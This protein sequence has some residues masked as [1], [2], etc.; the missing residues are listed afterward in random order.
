MSAVWM[1]LQY[2][3]SDY[4][5]GVPGAAWVFSTADPYDN[6]RPDGESWPFF[7]NL[8]QLNTFIP[9]YPFNSCGYYVIGDLPAN[10]QCCTVSLDTRSIYFG[11]H[12]IPSGIDS[13][14][15]NKDTSDSSLSSYMPAAVNGNR[16]CS[17]TAATPASLFGFTKILLLSDGSCVDTCSYANDAAHALQGCASLQ[18]TASGRI[19]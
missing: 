6:E 10:Q 5:K 15:T 19:S 12:G 11:T 14:I 3:A 13:L 9:P 17:L 1:E 4:C 2:A 7:Y 16:Y 18:C 8:Y